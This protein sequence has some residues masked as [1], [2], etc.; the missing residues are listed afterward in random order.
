[1][2]TRQTAADDPV[3]ERFITDILPRLRDEWRAQHVILFGSRVYGT[4][5]RWSDLDVIVVSEAFGGQRFVNR[6][7]ELMEALG[8]PLEVEPI[9]YTPEEFERKRQEVGIVATAWREGLRLI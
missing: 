5:G 3:I 4:P 6:A 7:G 9:C 1:M 8:G 2:A